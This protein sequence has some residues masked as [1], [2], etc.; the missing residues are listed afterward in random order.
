[1]EVEP[2]SGG[3]G[4]LRRAAALTFA[5]PLLTLAASCA[6]SS[7][8]AATAAGTGPGTG[9]AAPVAGRAPSAANPASYVKHAGFLNSVSCV[10][11]VDCTAVG[12]YYT[13]GAGPWLTLARHWNGRSWR[14]EPTPGSGHYLQLDAISCATTKMCVAVGTMILRWDGSAWAVSRKSSPFDAVSCPT[15][16]ECVA[17]GVTGGRAA[18][19]GLWNGAAWTIRPMPAPAHAVQSLRLASLSCAGRDFCV[20]VGDYSYGVGARP[21]P[22]A[23]DQAFAQ[24]WDGSGWRILATPN[25]ASWNQLNAVACTSARVCVAVGTAAGQFPFAERWNGASWLLERVPDPSSIGYANLSAVGCW[26]ATA[27]M[28]AGSYQASAIAEAR[29]ASG[30][31]LIHMPTPAGAQMI[32]V[33]AVSCPAPSMCVAVGSDGTAF[34][35]IWDGRAWTLR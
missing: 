29:D 27:C 31:R 3:I 34:T 26:S 5:L 20:A 11:P 1:M 13:S 32:Q 14:I 16:T 23:R 8:T 6:A 21:T 2:I 7:T 33:S 25:A 28:A 24:E 35:E 22:S 10:S 30:W 12:D 15:A 18:I 19:Y 17:V 4:P 9:T